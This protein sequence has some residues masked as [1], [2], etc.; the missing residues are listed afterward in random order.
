MIKKLFTA[1]ILTLLMLM[2]PIKSQAPDTPVVED[3]TNRI[4]QHIML[5]ET[6]EVFILDQGFTGG[7]CTGTVLE[8]SNKAVVLTA[9][10]CISIQPEIYVEGIK[11]EDYEVSKTYDL[12]LLYLEDVVE[13]KVPAVI[14]TK[15]ARRGDE[16]FG[17]GYSSITGFP[18][19]GTHFFSIGHNAQAK[20]EVRSGCSGGGLFNT[21]GELVG[22]VWGYNRIGL[23][24]YTPISFVQ[25]FLDEVGYV[26]K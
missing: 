16:L 8:N 23:R 7:M 21:E 26:Q 24:I 22:V 19:Y 20:M 4:I 10:H 6:H 1:G 17:L 15:N 12:A 11:V 5:A 13:D 3:D 9:K 18:L 25:K 2:I 14:G